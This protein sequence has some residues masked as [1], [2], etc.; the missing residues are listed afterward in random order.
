M[1]VTLKVTIFVSCY[2]CERMPS[3]LKAGL[4]EQNPCQT[5]RRKVDRTPPYKRSF[6]MC[7]ATVSHTSLQDSS[8]ILFNVGVYNTV[9]RMT[10]HCFIWVYTS[11]SGEFKV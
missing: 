1:Y 6:K 10:V 9:W 5:A 2:H 7:C 8:K 4:C 11:L 3:A